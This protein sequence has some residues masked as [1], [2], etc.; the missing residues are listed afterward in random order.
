MNK[1]YALIGPPASGKTNILQELAHYAIPEMVSHT[2]RKPR[3]DEKHGVHYYFV[4]KDEFQKYELIE[5]VEYSGNLYG[6]SKTEV[7]DKVKRCPVSM[8]AT[9]TNGLTQLK[10]LLANRLESIFIMVDYDTVIARM[11][12]RGDDNTL[13]NR[14]IEYANRT[15]EFN[16][17]NTANYVVKNTGA[18]AVAVR[19]VLAII[20]KVTLPDKV[21]LASDGVLTPSEAKS[22]DKS[23]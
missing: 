7:L 1:V 10:K 11:I 9:E 20:G 19:Q 15:G 5:R 17:W 12:N 14:R 13:I 23:V 8:V 22:Q 16:Q 18:L 2:T 4:S 3:P 6:L 21:D